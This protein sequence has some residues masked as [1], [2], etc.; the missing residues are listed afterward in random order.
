MF[1]FLFCIHPGLHGIHF[2]DFILLFLAAV[3][4]NN[5]NNLKNASAIL[6]F[7]AADVLSPA[8]LFLAHC[9]N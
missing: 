9:K 6:L 7:L 4:L 8:T 2:F 3:F 1:Y 5:F